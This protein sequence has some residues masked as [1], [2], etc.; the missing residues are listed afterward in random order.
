MRAA[1]IAPA[2]APKMAAKGAMKI[3][4]SVHSVCSGP[5]ANQANA[6]LARTIT[7]APMKAP[8]SGRE[9]PML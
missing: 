6:T 2:K 5:V 8:A 9:F 1:T 4:G 7:T 3:A